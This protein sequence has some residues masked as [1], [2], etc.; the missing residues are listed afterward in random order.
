MSEWNPQASA[1]ESGD[2]V[3]RFRV[4]H[5][6]HPLCGQTLDLVAQGR[7]WGEERVYYRDQ[8]GRMRFLPVCW[9]NLA[10]SDPFVAMAA[11]RA[12]FR[13]EDLIRARNRLKEWKG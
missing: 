4:T 8:D 13:V 10:A 2:A 7:E 3:P 6:F 11:G 5:P 12:H 1:P 9:T